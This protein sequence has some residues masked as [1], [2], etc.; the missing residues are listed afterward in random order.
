MK[1][2]ITKNKWIS[3]LLALLFWAALW[4]IIYLAV[5]QDVLI[6]SPADVLGRIGDLLPA[7]EFWRTVSLSFIRIFGGFFAAAAMGAILAAGTAFLPSLRMIIAPALSVVKATPVAS[8]I[9]LALVWLRSS[10]LSLF[11]SF[12]MVLPVFW[13]NLEAGI[14]ATDRELLEMA[15]VFRVPARKRVQEIYLPSI[16][17]YFVTACRSGIGMAWKAGI[18]A[19]V[20]GRPAHSIGK[21]IYNAK[22]YLETVDLF[23][24]TLIV[25]IL[26]MILEKLFLFLLGKIRMQHTGK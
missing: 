21:E 9:L 16:L 18:A 1:R 15:N 2:F 4:Q 7:A 26:S 6:A 11:I 20:L 12:L 17:P 25:I 23:A 5:D 14:L 10:Q 24:W 19:E 8:F 13:S 3:A 22:I